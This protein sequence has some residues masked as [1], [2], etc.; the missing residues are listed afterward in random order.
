LLLWASEYFVIP[1][2][3]QN[4]K[5]K[6]YETI[7]LH[8]VLYGYETW[9]LK[10]TEEHRLR[11]SENS[12]LRRIFG[13]ERDV[14]AQKRKNLYNG[15]LHSSYFSPNIIRVSKSRRM[16]WTGHVA[17]TDAHKKSEGKR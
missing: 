4:I 7:I 5:I 13:P 8:V 12:L 6:I 15:E 9:S 10:L 16:R 17:R 3:S 11:V 14:T 1:L 2:L